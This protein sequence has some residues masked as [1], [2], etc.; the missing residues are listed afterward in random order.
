[1]N[2]KTKRVWKWRKRKTTVSLF[3]SACASCAAK[4]PR[5][6]RTIWATWRELTASSCLTK[7][8]AIWSN[9]SST[10]ARRLVGVAVSVRRGGSGT[11]IDQ[12]SCNEPKPYSYR[13]VVH[14]MTFWDC[15]S[16]YIHVCILRRVRHFHL[17]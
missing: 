8:P 6:S 4:S 2:G 5:I 14:C 9:C 7:T 15:F 12:K 11:C 17:A 3:P 1:M 10:L 13:F 16:S